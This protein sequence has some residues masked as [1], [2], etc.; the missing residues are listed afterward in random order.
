M[1]DAL[2]M[3]SISDMPHAYVEIYGLK[4]KYPN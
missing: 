4:G 1:D 2:E 3:L